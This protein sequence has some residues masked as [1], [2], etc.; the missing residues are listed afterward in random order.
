MVIVAG[1]LP[2]A[3]LLA[4]WVIELG[5]GAEHRRH[6][7]LQADA[8]ALAASQ[9]F[10]DCGLHAEDAN[11]AIVDKAIEYASVQNVLVG[12]AEAQGRVKTVINGTD[13]DAADNS[14]GLPC[15]TGFV[16]VKLTDQDSPP[17]FDFVGDTDWH[18]HARVQVFKVERLNG[19]MP[20]AVP[21]PDP[22]KGS[23]IFFNEATGAVLA[24]AE[25]KRAK[26][27]DE[28]GLAMWK[29]NAPATVPISAP[30]VGV[31]IALSGG[32]STT[33]GDPLV[34]CYSTTGEGL[35]H[36]RG[37]SS[38]GTVNANPTT[39]L[40]SAPIPRSV[41]LEPA[42]PACDDA[43]FGPSFSPF[44]PTC[45]AANR[46]VAISAV[47]DFGTDPSNVGA[48]L[49]PVVG[50]VPG[51]PL[52]F[53]STAP[54]TARGV[55]SIPSGG[56]PLHIDLNWE[57]TKGKFPAD[58]T[59]KKDECPDNLLCKGTFSKVQRHFRN[60][61]NL[62]IEL[63]EVT[64]AGADVSS[65]QSGGTHS[66]DVKIGIGGTLGV[67]DEDSDP[68]HLRISGQNQT[69]ALACSDGNENL[70]GELSGG[71]DPWYQVNKGTACPGTKN[72]LTNSPQP[73]DCVVA[74][75]GNKMNQ[76]A[77][78]LNERILGD[79]KPKKCPSAGAFGHNN[80]PDYEPGDPRVILVFL[81]RFGA[82]GSTGSETVPVT[83]F[84]TF[85]ITGWNSSGGGFNNPCQGNGD[86]PAASSGEVVGHY[87]AHVNFPNDGNA[88]TNPCDLKE[89]R[90]C[91]PVLT[92]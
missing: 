45:V 34:T 44:G 32:S 53:D 92:E 61:V 1:F 10:G 13:Y 29:T 33:C 30:D 78:G 70:A 36:I 46:K 39:G 27:E 26:T 18:A 73:W 11:E 77:N 66:L 6:L 51:A 63:M 7:Q 76:V 56:G 16:D 41:S 22:Q 59:K 90:P 65:F 43:R 9:E 52:T 38:T 12:G 48:K 89:I 67:A 71:C 23:A 85:Y 17:F 14:A 3:V 5:N 83:G 55:V 47:V 68:V 79:D 24:T 8:G 4:A 81:T 21:V 35:V 62:P 80:W 2:I 72:A 15:D 25:L 19:L 86:D 91:T 60:D 49:T 42:T 75:T 74:L 69:Q 88:G 50:G 87:I 82:F 64:E 28:A 31:G 57:A 84:A 40:H 37:W 54:Y 20:M 58:S